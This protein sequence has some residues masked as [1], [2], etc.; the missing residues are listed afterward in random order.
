MVKR[1]TQV[2]VMLIL[3]LSGYIRKWNQ[4]QEICDGGNKDGK[5]CTYDD[6]YCTNGV[7][8]DS[9]VNYLT[10]YYSCVCDDIYDK[11]RSTLY[12]F[13]ILLIIQKS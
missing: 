12:D 10:D 8:I 1:I 11:Q 9:D 7:C 3:S 5:E 4:Q 13:R 6:D 2:L